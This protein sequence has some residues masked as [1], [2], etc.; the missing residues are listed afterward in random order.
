MFFQIKLHLA[1][2]ATL[3]LA[4][5]GA[6]PSLSLPIQERNDFKGKPL[7]AVTTR[8]GYPDFQS[9]VGGNKVYSWVMGRP[10]RQCKITVVMAGDVVGSYETLGDAPICVQYEAPAS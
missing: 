2:L 9:T 6:M 7:S 1:I 10:D 5:C 3:A 4:G 8:L